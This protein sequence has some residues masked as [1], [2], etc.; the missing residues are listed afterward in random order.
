M[1]DT[2]D[3]IG[4]VDSLKRSHERMQEA[5]QGFREAERR[6]M[7]AADALAE[8]GQPEA[9]WLG[10]VTAR[11]YQTAQAIADAMAFRADTRREPAP[12]IDAWRTRE[13]VSRELADAE[14]ARDAA[15][16]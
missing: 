8:Q 13:E 3:W 10:A 16:R 11:R 12:E 15:L 9:V 5:R 4:L 2:T 7:E 6:L 1:S 14:E